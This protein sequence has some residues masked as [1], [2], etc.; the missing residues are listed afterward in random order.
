[1]KNYDDF[2]WEDYTEKYYE[3]ELITQLGSNTQFDI[4]LKDFE[5]KDNELI[6]NDNL[7]PSSKEIIHLPYSLGV[8][9]VFECGVGCGFHLNNIHTV[10]P[11]IEINGCDYSQSQI[12][13]GKKYLQLDQ[14][15]FYS[16]LCVTDM[17]KSEQVK[18]L[19]KSEFVYCNAVLMHLCYD[20]VKS[21]IPNMGIISSKYILIMERPDHDYKL[22]VEKYLPEFEIIPGYKYSSSTL[23]LKRY[24]D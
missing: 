5:I 6:I 3:P 11:N 13:L 10:C 2:G 22:L 4:I 21:F 7:H 24:E 12:D 17:T 1:M 16:R 23:L 19:P 20:K 8:S 9:S 14:K 18:L 15:D